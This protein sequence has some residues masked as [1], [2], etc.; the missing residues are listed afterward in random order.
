MTLFTL[1]GPTPFDRQPVEPIQPVIVP[2]KRLTPA[3]DTT[4]VAAMAWMDSVD[5]MTA[6]EMAFMKQC[7]ISATEAAWRMTGFE[8]DERNLEIRFDHH[9][10]RGRSRPGLGMIAPG[11]S[12]WIE[13][14]VY[15]VKDF[16][17]AVYV[18]FDG[19]ESAMEIFQTDTESRPPR[20]KFTTIRAGA[21]PSMASIRI[22]V[23]AGPRDHDDVSVYKMAVAKAAAHIFNQRDCSPRSAL[24][25]S[26]AAEMLRPFRVRCLV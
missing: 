6:T 14:P 25:A 9:P 8:H 3:A 23:T 24:N 4:L 11:Y 26:G 12:P 7:I 18:D 5:D 21:F 19:N 20:V 16:T 2:E 22:R 17:E 10:T 13:M 1:D 15:P